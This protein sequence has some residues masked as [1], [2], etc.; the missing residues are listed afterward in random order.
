[1]RKYMT[2]IDAAA[3]TTE[4]IRCPSVTPQEGGALVLL[5]QLLAQNGFECARVDRNG[6]ANLFA[7]W[8]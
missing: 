5:E 6:T 2:Q 7:R 4:L 1:M 3:L 8:G